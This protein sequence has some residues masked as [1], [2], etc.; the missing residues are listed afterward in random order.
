[1]TY[2]RKTV[3]TLPDVALMVLGSFIPP[4]PT[5]WTE[6]F[7]RQRCLDLLE[8]ISLCIGLARGSKG[9]QYWLGV[10]L[11][12][13]AALEFCERCRRQMRALVSS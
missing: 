1:M 4:P 2:E 10:N 6:Y 13:K 9:H 8:H 7:F 12:L 3:L 5:K 11:R